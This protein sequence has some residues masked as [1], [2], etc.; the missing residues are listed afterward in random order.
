MLEPED[1]H[2]FGGGYLMPPS[3]MRWTVSWISH[4]GGAVDTAA[5]R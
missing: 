1:E 4:M 3:S 5:D 2:R